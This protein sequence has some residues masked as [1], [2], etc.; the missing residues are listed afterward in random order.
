MQLGRSAASPSPWAPCAWSGFGRT[1]GIGHT[2]HSCHDLVTCGHLTILTCEVTGRWPSSLLQYPLE[3]LSPSHF[4]RRLGAENLLHTANQHIAN[5]WYWGEVH[6]LHPPYHPRRIPL[7]NH[8]LRGM[9]WFHSVG[10]CCLSLD[11]WRLSWLR[12]WKKG[13]C[14]IHR[15]KIWRK[16]KLSG[17]SMLLTLNISTLLS[18]TVLISVP[19]LLI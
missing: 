8:P 13:N 9:S 19:K 1:S 12:K 4:Q 15:W 17:F 16:F 11:F 6:P 14:T 10:A 18:N 5:I 3:G 2:L 7:N